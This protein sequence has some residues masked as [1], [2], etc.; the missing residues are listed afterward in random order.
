MQHK[1]EHCA[2]EKNQICDQEP[3][4]P[5]GPAD[6]VQ[7]KEIAQPLDPGQENHI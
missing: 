1:L 3:S 5:F 7:N 4:L 2:A 6:E